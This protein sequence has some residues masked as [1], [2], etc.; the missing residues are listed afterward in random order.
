M[1]KLAI[2]GMVFLI[3]QS[4][5]GQALSQGSASGVSQQAFSTGGVPFTPGTPIPGI[6]ADRLSY[7]ALAGM[8]KSVPSGPVEIPVY[9]PFCAFGPYGIHGQYSIYGPYGMYGPG[10]PGYGSGLGFNGF[11]MNDPWILLK[12]YNEEIASQTAS[13]PAKAPAPKSTG[14]VSKPINATGQTNKTAPVQTNKTASVPA[15]KTATGS[16]D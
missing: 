9:N 2:A 7:W 8:G 10:G 12:Q 15:N 13:G 16:A 14:E 6:P 5:T 11:G 1:K 4:L 3:V